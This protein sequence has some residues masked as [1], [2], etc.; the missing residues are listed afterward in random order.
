M[1][2]LHHAVQQSLKKIEAV[3]A[4]LSRCDVAI[5]AAAV[6]PPQL[7]ELQSQRKALLATAFLAGKEADTKKLDA[8]IKPIQDEYDRLNAT[9]EA[10]G[11][12]KESLEADLQ[13][14][15]QEHASALEALQDARYEAACQESK[16]AAAAFDEIVNGSLREAVARVEVLSR[17]TLDLLPEGQRRHGT[18]LWLRHGTSLWLRHKLKD[19]P[20]FCINGPGLVASWTH[21]DPDGVA[22]AQ[23]EIVKKLQLDI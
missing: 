13:V 16:A 9:A 8:Q 1:K 22:A 21:G 14:A 6:A 15:Q 3:K 20:I 11:A 17:L 5:Q 10:A 18:S 12:A 23:D 7:D 2:E 4:Q 19:E